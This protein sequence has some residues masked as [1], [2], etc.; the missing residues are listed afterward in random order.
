MK[1][2][3]SVFLWARVPSTTMEGSAYLNSRLLPSTIPIQPFTIT[4]SSVVL[5]ATVAKFLVDSRPVHVS[6]IFGVI[7]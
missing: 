2:L 3:N 5:N 1:A 7:F 6:Y 4:P